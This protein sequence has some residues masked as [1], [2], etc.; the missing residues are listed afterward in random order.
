MKT[1]SIKSKLPSAAR[2]QRVQRVV[3]RVEVPFEQKMLEKLKEI[4]SSLPLPTVTA[5]AWCIYDVDCGGCVLVG[6]NCD[7][8]REVASLTKMM[9][10]YVAWQQFQ[11]IFP[12]STDLSIQIKKECTK[13]IGT[14]A[15]L[16]AGDTL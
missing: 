1:S 10:F 13:V 12:E 3:R 15:K 11:K 8:K 5:E 6:K 4:K 2:V 7:R 14:R 16:K 9:T